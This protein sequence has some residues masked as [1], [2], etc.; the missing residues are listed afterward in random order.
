MAKFYTYI[1]DEEKMIQKRGKQ[2]WSPSRIYNDWPWENGPSISSITRK[3]R[4]IKALGDKFVFGAGIQTGKITKINWTDE[5]EDTLIILYNNSKG[6]FEKAI[7]EF[8]RLNIDGNNR[9]YDSIDCEIS[10]LKAAGKIKSFFPQEEQKGKLNLREKYKN[11]GL[12]VLKEDPLTSYMICNVKCSFEH[13]FER[14]LSNYHRGCP[15]CA[16]AGQMSLTE[17]K[18]HPLGQTPA[19]LY[20]VQ[21]ED[22]TI[23]TGHCSMKGVKYRGKNWPPF[24]ILRDN[25]VILFEARR[26]EAATHNTGLRMAMYENSHGMTYPVTL[27]STL[28]VFPLQ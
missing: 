22:E 16:A 13:T 5:E 9:T 25:D 2:G 26:I 23:K 17:L 12:E 20:C 19:K 7:N 1:E 15:F 3:A 11:I 27:Q 10:I 6:E 24:K 4:R 18:D 14:K 21:F 28:L 8:K